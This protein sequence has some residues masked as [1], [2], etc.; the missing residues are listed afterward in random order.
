MLLLYKYC[1]WKVMQNIFLC[2]AISEL[3]NISEKSFN[4]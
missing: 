4:F 2:H 1:A 3:F